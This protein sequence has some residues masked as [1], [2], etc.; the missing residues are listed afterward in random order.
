MDQQDLVSGF[1]AVDQAASPQ[2]FTTWL[3]RASAMEF[4]SGVKRHTYAL[5][6][7]REGDAVLDVGCGTG[8]D[9][10][11][12]AHLVGDRGRAVG[13]DV[14]ETLIAEARQRT[15]GSDLPVE[16]H[17]GDARRLPFDDATFDACRSERTLIYLEDPAPALAEMRRVARPGARVVVF[18]PDLEALM[19]DASDRALTRAIV[20]FFCSGFPNSQTGRQLPALFRRTE[21]VE[22]AVTP[23]TLVVQEYTVA[24]QFF[25]LRATVE[26]AQADGT[27]AAADGQRWLGEL[28]QRDQEGRFFL[29]SPAFVVS[30]RK[31]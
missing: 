16:F 25:K 28:E 5:L 22:V 31:P 11:A 8:D 10:R 23:V 3:D 2:S 20:A 19:I 4:F 30:G 6:E 13:V 7:L 18:E 29:A 1:A 9:V 24:D 15:A 26:R 14:S 21:L 12:L 27:V 17:Q